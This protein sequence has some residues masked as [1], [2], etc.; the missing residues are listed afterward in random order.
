MI[1]T[2]TKTHSRLATII[3]AFNAGSRVESLTGYNSG[4][5]HMLEHCIFKGTPTRSPL[6]INRQIAYLGGSVNA[7]TSNEEVQYYI[8]APVENIDS[9]LEIMSD[10]VLNSMIPDD[11]FLKEKEVVKEEEISR[12]DSVYSFIWEKFAESF[13]DNYLATPVIGTQETI[14]KFTSEEV[15]AFYKA[16]CSPSHAVVSMCS[17]LSKKDSAALLRK[18]FGKPTGKIK[19]V[20]KFELSTYKPSATLEITKQGIEHTY[21][22]MGMPASPR[23][24]KRGGPQDILSA[25]M[26]SGM[27]SRLFTEVREKAGLVYSI[28][29]SGLEQEG[30]A[31][32]MIHFS[33]RDTNVQNALK[34]IDEQLNLI[35]SE[36]PS[37]EEVQ[38]AKNKIKASF[39]EANESSH[40]IA[41]W[42]VKEKLLGYPTIGEYLEGI[43]K[44]TP[45]DVMKSA[46]ELYGHDQRLTLICRGEE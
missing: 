6:E 3:V 37:E 24:G 43:D 39:Y 32:T 44:V 38:R 2:T 10:I 46:N 5:A 4:I 12:N 14:S 40:A 9:C 33:T 11:E 8:T 35:K 7:H 45:D 20:G 1:H 34:I 41:A 30:G 42:S 27:D 29:C 19:S 16:Y 25:I 22:F 36:P 23:N 28:G 31:C 15:R 17:N 21:V 18:H 13:F 26:G